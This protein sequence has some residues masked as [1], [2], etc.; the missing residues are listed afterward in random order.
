MRSKLIIFIFIASV[1]SI[2]TKAQKEEG[3]EKVPFKK[4][5]FTGGTI[6]LHFIP[7]LFL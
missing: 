4:N 3:K 1:I 5:L 2:H 6:H 7:I